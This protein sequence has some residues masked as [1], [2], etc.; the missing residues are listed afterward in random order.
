MHLVFKGLHAIFV[1]LFAH[2]AT[3]SSSNQMMKC[4]TPPPGPTKDRT[5]ATWCIVFLHWCF[6]CYAK[7]S[8]TCVIV[9]ISR[10][11][12]LDNFILGTL[13]INLYLNAI[14]KIF[15]KLTKIYAISNPIFSLFMQSKETL[16]KLQTYVYFEQH[17]LDRKSTGFSQSARDQATLNTSLIG[18]LMLTLGHI[19]LNTV[20]T[21]IHTYICIC[22][23]ASTSVPSQLIPHISIY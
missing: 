4:I 12:P 7:N 22:S 8:D 17:Y 13:L 15:K 19:M 2:F 5:S 23:V 1:D 16:F 14:E 18:K 11:I 21:Y 9:Y 3:L 10:Y 20:C 6:L